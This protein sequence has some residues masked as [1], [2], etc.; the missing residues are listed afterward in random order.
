MAVSTD[1]RAAIC[2]LLTELGPDQPTLC[3]GWQTR[4]LAAHLAVREH[5][6]DAAPGIVLAPFAGYTKRVQDGYAR[7][8]WPELVALV[9]GGPP[10]L[11]PTRIPAVD[12]LVNSV[13]FYVHHED[14][15]RGQP[16]WQP[17]DPDRRRDAAMWAGL[18]RAARLTLRK[19]PVGLVLRRPD[20]AE[21]VAKRGPDTVFVT[22]EPGELLLFAFG[23]DAVRLDFEGEQSSIAVVK[24]LSRG[25]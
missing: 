16:G 13:E 10:A 23:R 11:W 2:D 24:G 15:R 20:G 25:L 8:P 6:P 19:S 22:G 7:R 12:K 21:V 3:E 9:R 18:S 1:E 17:R 4:D 14:I 5:R